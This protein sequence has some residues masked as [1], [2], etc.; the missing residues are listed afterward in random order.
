MRV[1]TDTYVHDAAK[2]VIERIDDPDNARL[3]ISFVDAHGE[4]AEALLCVWGRQGSGRPFRYTFPEIVIREND[5]ER[6]LVPAPEPERAV[7]Q[8]CDWTGSVDLLEPI[9]HLAERVAAGEPM[10]LGECPKCGAL[11]H[12][13]GENAS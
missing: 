10:P 11:C 12:G 8:N 4:Q 3:R 9:K 5:V 6:T 2:I 13:E 7:C 1:N